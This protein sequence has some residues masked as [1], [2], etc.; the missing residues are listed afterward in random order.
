MGNRPPG[1][2]LD[3]KDNDKGY[4]KDNCHW[5]TQEQ[6]SNNTQ[7]SLYIEVDG[8]IK[9]LKQWCTDYGLSYP[10]IWYRYKQGVRAPELFLPIG[11]VGNKTLRRSV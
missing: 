8:K 1:G 4:S 3:R 5:A 7:R 11:V 6:Q 9:T 2:L 10:A